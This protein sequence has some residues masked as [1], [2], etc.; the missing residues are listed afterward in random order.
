M[1]NNVGSIRLCKRFGVSAKSIQRGSTT[2][3]RPSAM[4]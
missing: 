3:S 4:T 2:I 1:A